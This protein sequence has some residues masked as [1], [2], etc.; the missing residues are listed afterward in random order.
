MVAITSQ[1]G[2]TLAN[3]CLHANDHSLLPD[4]QMAEAA[5]QAHAIH[6]PRLLF[7]AADQ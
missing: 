6:L 5:D 3:S 4:V 2:I 7:E 1:L